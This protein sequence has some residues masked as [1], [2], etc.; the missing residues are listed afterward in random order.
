MP[1]EPPSKDDATTPP[2]APKELKAPPNGVIF[3]RLPIVSCLA[4]VTYCCALACGLS[5]ALYV[6]GDIGP[7]L[8]DLSELIFD[9]KLT[10]CRIE[11]VDKDGAFDKTPTGPLKLEARESAAI[12]I[13]PRLVA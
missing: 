6:E 3:K 2:R 4:N 12:P 10:V 8:Y 9:I 5:T 11:E 13:I 1:P 7:I